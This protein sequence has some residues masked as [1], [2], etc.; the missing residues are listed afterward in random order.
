MPS[1]AQAAP[2]AAEPERP[3]R[4]LVIDD[5]EMDR[6]R[7]LR[8][9]REAGLG[10]AATEV[11]TIDEMRAALWDQAFDLVFI[12]YLLAGEDGLSAVDLLA[13]QSDH[14]AAIMIAGEGRIDIAVEAMR[15]GCS[16]YVTK[17]DL[18]VA[19]LRK[20]VATAIERRLTAFALDAERQRR[21]ELERAVR[22]YANACSAEMRTILSA[23]L[24]RVRSLRGGGLGS[25]QVAN[26]AA[27]E[28]G[29]ER[30]WEA[31]PVFREGAGRTLERAG[32]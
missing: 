12:D 17:T 7:L 3:M 6:R 23:A 15:R 1:P 2:P 19:T 11:A 18:S 29:I 25:E 20:S 27:L 22:D 5:S 8:L 16:D 14:P 21:K 30:L 28:T 31:L 24:R 26:L 10:F 4:I 9:C 32:G 13:E